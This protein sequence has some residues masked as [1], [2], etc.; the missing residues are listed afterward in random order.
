MWA[1]PVCSQPLGKTE[2]TWRCAE[3]HSYDSAKEGYVNLLLANQKRSADPGDTREMMLNRRA[4]LEAGHYEPLAS[5]LSQELR[6][7]HADNV[8]D[9]GCGEGYYLQHF[10]QTEPE[11]AVWGLDISRDAVRMASKSLK[12]AAEFAVASSFHLPVLNSSVDLVLRVF[13]PGSIDELRR[14]LKPQGAFVLIVPGPRHLFS[15]KQALYDKPTLHELPAVPEGFLCESERRISFPL[16]LACNAAVNQLLAM[17]PFVW[18]GS[19]EAKEHLEKSAQFS[20]EADFYIR[21]YR[22]N[23]H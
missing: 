11:V 3:G 13:A 4:F 10:L 12:Q 22:Q 20:T 2:R 7:L 1:C 14:V 5:A 8:L 15:L 23:E 17:T 19:R 18:K 6:D 21:V 16:H 9:C